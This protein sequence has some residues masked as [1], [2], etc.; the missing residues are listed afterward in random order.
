MQSS[1][2]NLHTHQIQMHTI[3]K[4]ILENDISAQE[5]FRELLDGQEALIVD[6]EN[7]VKTLDN[8]GEEVGTFHRLSNS[9]EEQKTMAWILRR[10]V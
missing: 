8:G 7:R 9:L 1:K 2:V 6:L 5:M 4:D 10:Y 3:N